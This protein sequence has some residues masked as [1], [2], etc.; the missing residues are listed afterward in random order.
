MGNFAQ[1]NHINLEQNTCEL[2]DILGELDNP[3]KETCISRSSE[4]DEEEI[5]VEE[6][7]LSGKDYC[8]HLTVNS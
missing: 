3:G 6:D 2:T 5:E 7:S 4:F 8:C 1:D